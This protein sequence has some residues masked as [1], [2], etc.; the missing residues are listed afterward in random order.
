MFYQANDKKRLKTKLIDWLLVHVIIIDKYKF[1]KESFF[2]G[3]NE[4]RT[5]TAKS[6]T[7]II[8]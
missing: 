7:D 8:L 3:V 1:I 6:T 5:I 4:N 2:K